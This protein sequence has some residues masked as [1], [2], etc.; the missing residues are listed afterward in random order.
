MWPKV[1][2]QLIEL[3]PHATRLVPLAEKFFQNRGEV[4]AT[5]DE[6]SRK[7]LEELRAELGKGA[8]THESLYRQLNEQSAQISSALTEARATR[9]AVEAADRRLFAVE[10]RLATL[11]KWMIGCFA[12]LVVV[13][14]GVVVL[15]L[16]H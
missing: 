12:V 2:A 1:L 16:R 7:A 4:S 9:S 10:K 3:L 5:L 6:P 13:L 11:V 8:A 15:L 14:A